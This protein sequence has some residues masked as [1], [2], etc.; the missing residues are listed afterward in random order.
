MI[1]PLKL[2]FSDLVTVNES[3]KGEKRE[4]VL[5]NVIILG[6]GV[7]PSEKPKYLL[8]LVLPN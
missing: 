6:N 5:G 3:M 2:V 7:V 8:H 1:L 4:N